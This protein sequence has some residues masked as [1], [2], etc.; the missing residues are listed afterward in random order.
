MNHSE[1]FAF[2]DQYAAGD[3]STL[4]QDAFMR[5][6]QRA[7]RQEVSNLLFH[8]WRNLENHPEQL[9]AADRLEVRRIARKLRWKQAYMH[10]LIARSLCRDRLMRQTRISLITLAGGL[11]CSLATFLTQPDQPTI[12]IKQPISS[13][14][15][16]HPYAIRPHPST[17]FLW[18]SHHRR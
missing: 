10:I 5:Y 7:T 9:P 2:V 3:F 14:Y 18:R 8:L 13:D 15:K 17:W 16:Y 11:L 6:L 4:Q 12:T 1:A